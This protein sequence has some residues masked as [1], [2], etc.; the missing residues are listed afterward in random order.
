MINKIIKKE[1]DSDEI[2]NGLTMFF[3][4]LARFDYEDK[5]K[6]KLVLN[7][8]LLVSAPKGSELDTNFLN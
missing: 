4:L 2:V 1:E 5:Q 6:E 3:D 8:D 7:S